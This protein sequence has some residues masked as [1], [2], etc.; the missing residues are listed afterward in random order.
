MFLVVKAKAVPLHATMALGWTGLGI[1]WGWVVSVTLRPRFSPWE[2]APVPTVQDA[3]WAPKPVWTQ[4]LQEKILSPLPGIEP[5][6]PGRLARNQTLYW[7][8]YPAHMFLVGTLNTSLYINLRSVVIDISM[9]AIGCWVGL[10]HLIL[11]CVCKGLVKLRSVAQ[12]WY[13]M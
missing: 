2:R 10:Y 13:Q 7:L 8:S 9:S 6:S 11:P 5:R 3:G 1:R 12:Q 4:R